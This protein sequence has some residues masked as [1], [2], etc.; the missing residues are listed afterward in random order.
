MFLDN[1]LNIT[2]DSNHD[3]VFYVSGEEKLRLNSLGI[4][5]S[6]NL[7]F[8]ST[9]YIDSSVQ[10]DAS[11]D[12]LRFLHG[13][14]QAFRIFGDKR[15]G[16]GNVSY[17]RLYPTAMSYGLDLHTASTDT[18]IKFTNDSSPDYGA[19][20]R[21]T[22]SEME[23]NNAAGGDIIFKQF[24]I[25]SMR[26]ASSGAIGIDNNSPDYCLHMNFINSNNG[27]A[28]Y[29]GA[30]NY[31]GV[32]SGG[33]HYGASMGNLSMFVNGAFVTASSQVTPSDRRIKTN[34]QKKNSS[35][36]LQNL[37]LLKPVN[38]HYKDYINN[39]VQMQCGFVAQDI[40][41]VFPNTLRIAA[42]YIPN[43]LDGAFYFIDPSY[44]KIIQFLD[45]DT[46]HLE[47]DA[48]GNFYSQIYLIDENDKKYSSITISKII[49]SRSIQIE[50][51][52]ELTPNI[53]VYGQHIDNLKTLDYDRIF[54][55]FASAMKEVDAQLQNE[56]LKT[57]ELE[58][59]LHDL[60][61]SLQ[62]NK[63]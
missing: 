7:L 6:G 51:D 23:I 29:S 33:I 42:D 63:G 44:N 40:E 36:C 50:T 43:I 16:I 59:E 27:G 30:L 3:A 35:E 39:S 37:R 15:L 58:R 32:D 19:T 11:V 8:D 60:F 49:S 38:Y 47:L 41:H 34:I 48:S 56:K 54:M 53:F 21:H 62:T 4:D 9:T 28:T 10:D 26:I 25:E 52:E 61:A 57:I 18:G 12:E 22:G 2:L 13:N 24:G 45:F 14:T 31:F 17:P 55:T 5:V 20:I 46:N 1:S